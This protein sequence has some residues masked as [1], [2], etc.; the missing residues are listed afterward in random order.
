MIHFL[1]NFHLEKS[2][3][4]TQAKFPVG[5]FSNLKGVL[6]VTI[7]HYS[8]LETFCF[9]LKMENTCNTYAVRG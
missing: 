5:N 1:K 4:Y 9:V 7:F 8:L 3:F 2:H 6:W